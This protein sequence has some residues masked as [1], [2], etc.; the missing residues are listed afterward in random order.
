MGKTV[1]L[2][3]DGKTT[4]VHT[5]GDNVSDV[6]D[7]EDISVGEHDAVAPGVDSSVADGQTVSV[8][9]GRPLEVKVD[10]QRAATG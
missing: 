10:G 2:S 4:Q 3:V 6:L 5:F 9:F 1:T 7:A 8:K